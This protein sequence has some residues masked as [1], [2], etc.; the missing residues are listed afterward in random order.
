MTNASAKEDDDPNPFI[1]T[2]HL[3]IVVFLAKYPSTNQKKKKNQTY[4]DPSPPP[5]VKFYLLYVKI[6]D[7][8]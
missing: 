1:G 6:M 4:R 2:T 3:P 8:K 7:R 5:L